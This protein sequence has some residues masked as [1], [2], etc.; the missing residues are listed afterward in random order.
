MPQTLTESALFAKPRTATQTQAFKVE[1][2][3]GENG[4]VHDWAVPGNQV[5]GRAVIAN[6]T[7]SPAVKVT[8]PVAAVRITV[9]TATGAPAPVWPANEG[10]RPVFF[11][12]VEWSADGTT[13]AEVKSFGPVY[14][15]VEVR[16]AAMG[17]GFV[18][19]AEAVGGTGAVFTYSAELFAA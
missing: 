13:W 5:A 17:P 11:P 8:A 12:V 9:H 6:A 7:R 1:R 2:F 15:G 3:G 4:S 14:S 16:T 19:I 10:D 18:R